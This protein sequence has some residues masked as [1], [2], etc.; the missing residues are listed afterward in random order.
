MIGHGIVSSDVPDH[1]KE[2]PAWNLVP[3]VVVVVVDLLSVGDTCS[4]HGD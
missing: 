4:D 3:R 2:T 1:Q